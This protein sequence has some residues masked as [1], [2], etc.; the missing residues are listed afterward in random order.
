MAQQRFI[1]ND[2]QFHNA[3]LGKSLSPAAQLS[4]TPRNLWERACSRKR[5][6][7]QHQC[8]LC[9]RLREQARSHKGCAYQKA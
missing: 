1:F 4:V 6:V 5:R 8:R 2:Q 3:L 9:R 7:R